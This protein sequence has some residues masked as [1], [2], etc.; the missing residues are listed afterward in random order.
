MLNKVILTG[1]VGRAPK[2][3]LTQEGKELVTFSLATAQHWRDEEGEWQ[4]ATDWHH[5]AVFRG[6]TIRWLKDVLKSGDP[7]YVEGKLTYHSWIDKFGQKR[8]S[9]HVVITNRD[10]RVEYLRPS[11]FQNTT[12]QSPNLISNLD[13]QDKPQPVSLEAEHGSE[14]KDESVG[15]SLEISSA[16]ALVELE[17]QEENQ[18]LTH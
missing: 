16:K 3:C 4:S 7:L 17:P 14:Q 1:K 2:V 8:L 10:G 18:P 9:S 12:S 15:L 13:V 11:S 6:S 5:I